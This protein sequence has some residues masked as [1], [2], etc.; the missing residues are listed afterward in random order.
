M[1]KHD[2]GRP[3]NVLGYDLTP[4]MMPV[5]PTTEDV[6]NALMASIKDTAKAVTVTASTEDIDMTQ[7]TLGI[8]ILNMDTAIMDI[9]MAIVSCYN[10]DSREFVD[11]LEKAVQHLAL[12]VI[13]SESEN[14]LDNSPHLHAIVNAAKEEVL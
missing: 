3:T 8:T 12:A 1:S 13:T 11:A 6:V 14:G 4:D 9:N 2:D 7:D 5:H 10:D